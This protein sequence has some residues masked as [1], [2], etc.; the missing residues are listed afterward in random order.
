MPPACS[1]SIHLSP[2]TPQAAAL[3]PGQ[4]R[5]PVC[6]QRREHRLRGLGVPARH[7]AGQGL[8]LGDLRSEPGEGL[9]QFTA[10]RP[11]AEDDEP[12]RRRLAAAQPGPEVVGSQR[13]HL[14][15]ARNGRDGGPCT[16][17]NDHRSGGQA[18]G[19]AVGIGDL[20][21]PG[22]DEPGMALHHLDAETGIALDAVMGRDVG[23]HAV[24]PLHYVGEGNGGRRVRQPPAPGMGHLVGQRCAADQ[25][26]RGHAAVVQ[27]VAAHLAR[28][29]QRHPRLGR[30]RDIGR[31]Q[32]GRTRA[33]HKKVAV[34]P[35]RPRPSRID[36]APPPQVHSRP[37]DPGNAARNANE[38]S[39]GSDSIPDRLSSAASCVPAFT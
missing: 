20:D 23:D 10:D 3:W 22:G 21:V 25:R 24:D 13:L 39:V 12:A 35:R 34:E 29:D 19:R 9:R 37:R 36:A 7:H 33:D 32:P 4:H 31:N 30:R 27:A 2:S 38:A 14:V 15:E 1:T 26:L 28:L 11:A 8:D 5:H 6:L 18:T 16:G 17:R